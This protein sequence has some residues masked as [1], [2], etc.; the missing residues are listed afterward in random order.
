MENQSKIILVGAS[1]YSIT[2]VFFNEDF[3]QEKYDKYYNKLNNE[4][5]NIVKI[6]N[7]RVELLKGDEEFI[8]EKIKGEKF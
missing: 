4:Y 7:G 6:I 2:K 1:K 3:S 8:K 5:D